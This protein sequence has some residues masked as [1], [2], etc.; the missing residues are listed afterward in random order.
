MEHRRFGPGS[1][2]VPGPGAWGT[3]TLDRVTFRIDL[4]C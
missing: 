3:I 4:T 2:A 1:P